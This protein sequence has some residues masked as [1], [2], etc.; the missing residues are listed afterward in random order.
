MTAIR[1]DALGLLSYAVGNTRLLGGDNIS[2][3]ETVPG[4]HRGL[5]DSMNRRIIDIL[6]GGDHEGD[7]T[8]PDT[9][10]EHALQ[11]GWI[12]GGRGHA[13]PD[14]VLPESLPVTGSHHQASPVDPPTRTIKTAWIDKRRRVGLRKGELVPRDDKERQWVKTQRRYL[15]LG[16]GRVEPA[17]AQEADVLRVHRLAGYAKAPQESK[18]VDESAQATQPEKPAG[19]DDEPMLIPDDIDL[20]SPAGKQTS[21]LVLPE[22]HTQSATAP[23]SCQGSAMQSRARSS[24]AE[25]DWRATQEEPSDPD[26][27]GQL[28]F[29]MAQQLDH[30]LNH[31]TP[32]PQTSVQ[33]S[34]AADREWDEFG[35]RRRRMEQLVEAHTS[36]FAPILAKFIGHFEKQCREQAAKKGTVATPLNYSPPIMNDYLTLKIDDILSLETPETCDDPT[37]ANPWLTDTIV[38]FMVSHMRKCYKSSDRKHYVAESTPLAYWIS[39]IKSLT[40]AADRHVQ[41][42]KQEE[43]FVF[44]LA[45]MPA[46]TESISLIYNVNESHW[47]HILLQVDHEKK[48]GTIIL[49]DSMGA[50]RNRE[51]GA[52]GKT[53]PKG[54]TLATVESQLPPLARLISK[55]PSLQWG[56]VQWN[57]AVTTAPCRQQTNGSDC[58]V[59]AIL[60]ATEVACGAPV[61]YETSTSDPA[62]GPECRWAILSVVH[63][64]Y[65]G[66][67][68]PY[69]TEAW[70]GYNDFEPFLYV[71]NDVQAT[72][73]PTM[74]AEGHETSMPTNPAP[75]DNDASDSEA[76]VDDDT[77][78]GDIEEGLRGA[79]KKRLGLTPSHADARLTTAYR[80]AR[81]YAS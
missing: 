69:S 60:R 73:G 7:G 51:P 24:H 56:D 44:P 14:H 18:P 42:P 76:D 49:H 78:E 50:S 17:N 34:A 46:D 2:L 41:N 53:P 1:Q 47:V 79:I 6:R 59:F 16:A 5:G 4:H 62:K 27:Q 70:L 15:D 10:P 71:D 11:G 68:L 22:G 13:G 64:V 55:R 58:G 74:A 67:P 33:N 75:E 12:A 29:E 38:D 45:D 19:L 43:A 48:E 57:G 37:L 54:S 3:L 52:N 80:T 31:V 28:D 9:L 66:Q 8:S 63:Q 40:A 39:G 77:P 26:V 20:P 61:D 23:V 21:P 35:K 32:V 30:E 72:S 36:P 65:F 81:V 25:E